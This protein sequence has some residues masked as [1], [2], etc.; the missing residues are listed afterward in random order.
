MLLIVV[1][2]IDFLT[3][4]VIMVENPWNLGKKVGRKWLKCGKVWIILD[5]DLFQTR[6]FFSNVF[7]LK[8]CIAPLFLAQTKI[9]TV[10]LKWWL[11]LMP[12]IENDSWHENKR[13]LINIERLTWL[14]KYIFLIRSTELKS[15]TQLRIR[16]YDIPLTS[17]ENMKKYPHRMWYTLSLFKFQID[18]KM[19]RFS[20]TIYTLSLGSS[21]S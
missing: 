14:T 7:I 12:S 8:I 18:R 19:A 6:R 17:Y 9:S 11:Q 1:C 4:L 20:F 15:S 5:A 16:A 10:L 3:L 2:F 21:C 13:I